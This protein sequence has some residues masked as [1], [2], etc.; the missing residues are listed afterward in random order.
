MTSK[1]PRKRG[2]LL[3]MNYEHV[4]ELNLW[5]TAAVM[6]GIIAP[7]LSSVI[8]SPPKSSNKETETHVDHL[9]SVLI[10]CVRD[11]DDPEDLTW[12]QIRTKLNVNHDKFQDATE[13]IQEFNARMKRYG[14]RFTSI[15]MERHGV[16]S[17]NRL[18]WDLLEGTATT[19]AKIAS[20]S[21]R[22]RLA[23]GNINEELLVQLLV[24]RNT[25]SADAPTP[26]EASAKADHQQR[27]LRRLF[28]ATD[29]QQEV[30][31]AYSAW[32]MLSGAF[33]NTL[34]AKQRLELWT[35]FLKT[36]AGM[37]AVLEK[38]KTNGTLSEF[39]K[40]M[41]Q[42]G[43][44][45]NYDDLE[46]DELLVAHDRKT[47]KV[48]K[49]GHS[50]AEMA[51]TSHEN[52]VIA[53]YE[54]P[55]RQIDVFTT[56]GKKT[57]KVRFLGRTKTFSSMIE[58]TAYKDGSV[59]D[60]INGIMLVVE[61]NEYIPLAWQSIIDTLILSGCKDIQ[62]TLKSHG[63][64]LTQTAFPNG[65]T[66]E[67]PY[68]Y[69]G[70]P[71]DRKAIGRAQWQV[72]FANN[73][74]NQATSSDRITVQDDLSYT[75]ENGVPRKVEIQIYSTEHYINKT[76]WSEL[77]DEPYKAGKLGTSRTPDTLSLREK[78]VPDIYL[79]TIAV[80]ILGMSPEDA[81][82]AIEIIDSEEYRIAMRE[83]AYRR[84]AV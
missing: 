9:R 49:V 10:A 78:L 3:T 56:D 58:K 12:E 15:F 74:H 36:D 21:I 14:H 8:E 5:K 11:P 47:G 84:I 24:R 50:I 51:D 25:R 40:K 28:A 1:T 42:Y 45:T 18:A 35:T 46:E 75:D 65:F 68:V 22:E 76:K 43:L 32:E 16:P 13:S 53:P 55:V 39:E 70:D 26:A 63:G 52:C 59:P 83:G 79:Y 57:L 66:L 30:K 23:L 34:T 69:E 71:N 7:E 6:P 2:F 60:D 4:R 82:E 29:M 20:E 41:L 64:G 44:W 17:E 73:G 54:I 61:S 62:M 67:G 80:D 77:A 48:V 81:I 31:G 33:N 27:N 72:P 38:R 37:T 19:E